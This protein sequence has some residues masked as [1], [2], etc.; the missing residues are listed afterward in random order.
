MSISQNIT[1]E[2]PLKNNYVKKK[3]NVIIIFY[4]TRI[5]KLPNP[6]NLTC[7]H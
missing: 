5:L 4:I 6:S 7:V 2:F 3:S 1:T